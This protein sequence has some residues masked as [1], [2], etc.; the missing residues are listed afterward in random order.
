VLYF[1]LRNFL[2]R[3]KTNCNT[4]RAWSSHGSP[5][6]SHVNPRLLLSVISAKI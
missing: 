3:W 5:S 1:Y 6:V 4:Y 2:E